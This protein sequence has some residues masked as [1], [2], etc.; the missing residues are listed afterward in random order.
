MQAKF[1]F[2][3]E[4]N[5]DQ[6]DILRSYRET[7]G[8]YLIS[9]RRR[10]ASPLIEKL[11]ENGSIDTPEMSSLKS[12]FSAE[13]FKTTPHQPPSERNPSLPSVDFFFGGTDGTHEHSGGTSDFQKVS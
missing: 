7:R 1:Y 6:S 3:Q 12:Q 8:D 11:R 5:T 4:E 13:G 2:K 9:S 10:S